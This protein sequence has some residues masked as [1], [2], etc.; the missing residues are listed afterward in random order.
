MFIRLWGGEREKKWEGGSDEERD[1]AV[2]RGRSSLNWLES[3]SWQW[4]KAAERNLPALRDGNGTF[5][6]RSRAAPA[7]G[8]GPGLALT[9]LS[10]LT[11]YALVLTL[12][13]SGQESPKTCRYAMGTDSDNL[14]LRWSRCSLR[15]GSTWRVT[16]PSPVRRDTGGSVETK[17]E[18]KSILF[19]APRVCGCLSL[20][21]YIVL[22]WVTGSCS[23]LDEAQ[24]TFCFATSY[25]GFGCFSWP[26]CSDVG[27]W[28]QKCLHHMNINY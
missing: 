27:R 26:T 16:S 1:G 6:P 24:D 21:F 14:E 11:R 22:S 25:S 23:H 28:L 3:E 13:C 18:E 2:W 17:L 7:A 10:R 19:F 4:C 12:C 9:L 20:F 15:S 8:G 5:S